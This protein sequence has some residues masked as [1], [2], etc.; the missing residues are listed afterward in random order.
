MAAMKTILVRYGELA[1][2]SEPVRRDFEH[3]LAR[4]IRR[5]LEKGGV[6]ADVKRIFGRVLVEAK[7]SG[8]AAEI[9]KK[10]FGVVSFSVCAETISG[11]KDIEKASIEVFRCARPK[12]TNTFRVETNRVGSHPYSSKQ[13]N[14]AVGRAIAE[15][16]RLKVNLTEPDKTLYIDI[17][18][19]QAFIFTEKTP[20]PGGFPAGVQGRVLYVAE[21]RNGLLSAWLMMKRGAVPVLF[22]AGIGKKTAKKYACLLEEWNAGHKIRY[23]VDIKRNA[24]CKRINKTAEQ[25][26]CLGIISGRAEIMGKNSFKLPVF[27]PLIGFISKEIKEKIKSIF[28]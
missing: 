19:R 1:L 21:D 15:K 10:T 4:N 8:K 14:E 16:F 25:E 18:D 17:R 12:K 11:I 23:Y 2:K 6:K 22:F 5:S 9:L 3:T 7:N 28:G 27:Y 26:R 20:G 13:V 24:D